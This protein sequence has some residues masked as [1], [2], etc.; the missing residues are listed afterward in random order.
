MKNRD[1]IGRVLPDMKSITNTEFAVTSPGYGNPDYYINGNRVSKAIYE[2]EFLKEEERARCA[3][4]HNDAIDACTTALNERMA[5]KKDIEG[6][7]TMK[8][9]V[10]YP[11]ME[12]GD[13]CECEYE[14]KKLTGC[15]ISIN[16]DGRVH[17]TEQSRDLYLLYATAGRLPTIGR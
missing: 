8:G 4:R 15:R 14:G 10:V 5:S 16:D 3:I 11:R 1:D 9:T 17:A 2:A 6:G 13:F 7:N 12:H